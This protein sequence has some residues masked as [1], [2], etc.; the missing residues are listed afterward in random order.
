MVWGMDEIVSNMAQLTLWTV[1]DD[2]QRWGLVY[3]FVK[4][5][6]MMR[7]PVEKKPGVTLSI[8]ISVK[9]EMT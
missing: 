1:D 4:R 3:S 6:V 5:K 7:I 2:I 9:L 8:V